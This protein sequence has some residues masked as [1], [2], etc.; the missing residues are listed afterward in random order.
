MATVYVVAPQLAL[1]EALSTK[2]ISREIVPPGGPPRLQ[3]ISP[4]VLPSPRQLVERR[5]A[6]TATFGNAAA[7]DISKHLCAAFGALPDS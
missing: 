6:S 4:A 7:I 1:V 3:Q 2:A 5:T